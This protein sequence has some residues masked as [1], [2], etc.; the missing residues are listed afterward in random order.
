MRWTAEK[1]EL[2]RSGYEIDG[3]AVLAEQLD[4][5]RCFCAKTCVERT[6]IS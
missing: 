1:I 5:Q 2:I 4:K 6:K 3:P